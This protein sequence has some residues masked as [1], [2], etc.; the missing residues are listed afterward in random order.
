ALLKRG[1][2]VSTDA[3]ERAI[4]EALAYHGQDVPGFDRFGMGAEWAE[5]LRC[6]GGRMK[7]QEAQRMQLACE[8]QL[9]TRQ[10]RALIAEARRS[11]AR[12]SLASQLAGIGGAVPRGRAPCGVLALSEALGQAAERARGH[13]ALL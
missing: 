3:C 8:G 4:G 12:L 10:R 6:W 9:G 5:S 13:E 2:E 1:R 11:W 7:Q